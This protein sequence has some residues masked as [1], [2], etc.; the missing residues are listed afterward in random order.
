MP[1]ILTGAS[2]GALTLSSLAT[3]RYDELHI[4][5]DHEAIFSQSIISWNGDSILDRLKLAL[6]SKPI[7]NVDEMKHFIR[8]NTQDLTFKEVYEK[9]GWILNIVVSN[10]GFYK[11]PIV[12]NYLNAPDVLLWSAA[13]ASGSI[14]DMFA[15]A[16][17]Y[18]KNE[19]GNI[20]RWYP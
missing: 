1:R 4:A 5:M 12:L 14:P 17:L 13:L 20:E 2:A 7:A 3:F 18:I 15:P 8:H 11:P 19:Q 16:E 9:N 6:E 10:K